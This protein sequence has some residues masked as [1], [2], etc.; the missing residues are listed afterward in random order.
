MNV[1][2]IIGPIMVGP[3]SSHTAGAVR[4]GRVARMILGEDVKEA[5]IGLH[6]SFSKTAVGHGTD[7]AILG[8]LMGFDVDD[9]R[10]RES[11]QIASQ[12][13]LKYKMENVNLKNVHPNTA[14]IE[15]IGISGK[16]AYIVGS[17][18]GGGN[19]AITQVNGVDVSIGGDYYTLVIAHT[20]MPGVISSVTNLLACFNIN[21][22]FMRVYRSEKRGAAIMVIEADEEIL[23]ETASLIERLPRITRATLV[24]PVH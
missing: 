15:I 24:R 1:F 11:L 16:K 5:Y 2:D 10:I 8:G 3:S 19:I 20:D 13:G 9:A 6:G 23:E 12:S 4:I 22:A 21:I 18:V 14:K 17:S 7:R